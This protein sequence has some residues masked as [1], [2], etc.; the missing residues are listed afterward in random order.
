M[1]RVALVLLGSVLV[2]ACGDDGSE[3]LP[4]GT[5]RLVGETVNGTSTPEAQLNGALELTATEYGLGIARPAPTGVLASY[6]VMGKTLALGGGGMVPF[7]VSG[8]QV[9]LRPDS[10]HVWTFSRVTPTAA[11]TFPLSGTVQVTRGAPQFAH[12]R[13]ALIRYVRELGA[14]SFFHD[15]RDDRAIVLDGGSATFDFTRDRAALGTDRITFGATAGISIEIVVVYDDRDNSG[16]LGELFSPC[17]ETTKDCIRGISNIVLA[18]RDGMSAE[19][20]ASPYALLRTGW[21]N[22][23]TVTDQRTG[24]LG[25]VSA[26]PDKPISHEVLVVVD[27]ASVAAPAFQL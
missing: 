17:S 19:L 24:R 12:P 2:S 5:F 8:D 10:S 16:T 26:D 11:E 22:A 9:T 14:V 18:F 21:S 23:V 1:K 15:P 25:L 6:T 4:T 20:A 13:A 27:P 7:S 3:T